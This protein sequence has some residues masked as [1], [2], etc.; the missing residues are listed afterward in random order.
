[1]ENIKGK[2]VTVVNPKRVYTFCDVKDDEYLHMV[3]NIN[4]SNRNDNNGYVDCQMAKIDM[5]ERSLKLRAN[6]DMVTNLAGDKRGVFV[7]ISTSSYDL[8]D[9]TYCGEL[10]FVEKGSVALTNIMNAK[11][12]YQAALVR[13]ALETYN[14]ATE[15]VI[16]LTMMVGGDILTRTQKIQKPHPSQLVDQCKDTV[17]LTGSNQSDRSAFVATKRTECVNCGKCTNGV[18]PTCKAPYCCRACREAN[19]VL[20]KKNCKSVLKFNR[21]LNKSFGTNL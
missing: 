14:P 21:S 13:D 10:R 7:V 3:Q 2:D 16:E 12:R 11:D 19:K 9:A 1:M 17:Q 6:H 4:E 18:C 5:I 15:L 8:V 20:H